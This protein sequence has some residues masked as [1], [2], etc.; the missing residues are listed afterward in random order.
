[1]INDLFDDC[2]NR[3]NTCLFTVDGKKLSNVT[4]VSVGVGRWGS[5]DG[6]AKMGLGR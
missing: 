3:V 1:M 2:N 6:G 4:T 5:G